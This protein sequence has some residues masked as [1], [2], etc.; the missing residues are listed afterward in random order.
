M[1]SILNVRLPPPL[2]IACEKSFDA[3]V[4][5][6]IGHLRLEKASVVREAKS[7]HCG[8]LEAGASDAVRSADKAH[9]RSRSGGRSLVLFYDIIQ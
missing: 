1:Y 3:I 4:G 9:T 5:L 7:M 8:V 2:F 6:L